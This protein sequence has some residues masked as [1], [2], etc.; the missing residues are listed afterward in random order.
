MAADK[1]WLLLYT[2]P[3]KERRV[4]DLLR[5]QDIEVYLPEI[6][7]QRQSGLKRKPFFPCYL[8]IQVDPRNGA[9]ADVRWTP[10]LRY[11]VRAGHEPVRVPAPV[12]EGIRHRLRQMGVV[13][14][15]DRFQQGDVVRIAQGPFDGIEAVFD[16]R[17]SAQGRVRVFLQLVDRL[18]ATEL[19]A[20]DLQPGH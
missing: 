5:A 15:E 9:L 16:R 12:V 20:R 1:V 17:L 14:P 11:I 6:T 13:R 18:V 7:V 10:G 2:K 8:F 19:D 4:Q 3:Y